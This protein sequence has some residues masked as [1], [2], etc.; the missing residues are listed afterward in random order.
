MQCLAEDRLLLLILRNLFQSIQNLTCPGT[1]PR[2]WLHQGRA[3]IRCATDPLLIDGLR[4]AGTAGGSPGCHHI[5]HLGEKVVRFFSP[6]SILR[7]HVSPLMLTL[8]FEV[9]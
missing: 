3:H 5:I 9:L 6:A 4:V 1:F 8:D 2:S 7:S